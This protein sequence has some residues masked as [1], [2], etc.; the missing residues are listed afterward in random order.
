M[1]FLTRKLTRRHYANETDRRAAEAEQ[2]AREVKERADRVALRLERRL[3][4]NHFAEG[5]GKAWG[6]GGRHRA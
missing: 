2:R 5:L 6:L 3:R 1:N 4:Q